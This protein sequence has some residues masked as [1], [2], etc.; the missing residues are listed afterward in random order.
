MDYADNNFFSKFAIDPDAELSEYDFYE[1]L[2][3]PDLPR[4]SLPVEP[5]IDP[6]NDL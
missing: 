2:E 1:E 6:E 4:D 3:L 5:A